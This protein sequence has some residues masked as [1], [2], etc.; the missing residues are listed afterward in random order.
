MV[1]VR[2]KCGWSTMVNPHNAKV[3]T[4]GAKG[5]SRK[6]SVPKPKKF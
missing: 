1:P 2:C 4:C 3:I 5:C 6:I